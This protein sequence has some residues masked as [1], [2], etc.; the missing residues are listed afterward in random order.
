V[1]NRR[2]LWAL[3]WRD[4]KARY[5]GSV[6]GFVWTFLNPLLLM[7][8]YSLVFAVYMRVD[9]PHYPIFVF[10]GLLP[11]IWFSSAVVA[12]SNAI[13]EGASL[14]KRVAF[15]PQVLPAVTVTATLI[16][17]MLGLPL[18]L[19]FMVGFG[20]PIRV[21]VLTLPLTIAFQFVFTLGVVIAL[22]MLSV[23]YRD[24]HHLLASAMTLWFFLTPVLYPPSLVPASLQ[25]FLLLNPMTS[26][27]AAYQ[28]ALYHGQAPELAHLV[29]GGAFA[30]GALAAALALCGRWR[31]TLVEEV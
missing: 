14:I 4:L 2:V 22:S 1:A 24:L 25:P 8:I 7:A 5:R 30:F 23:R 17:F 27:I 29:V 31:W 13:V 6:L 9:I 19:A 15:P 12:G 28:A 11:W 10:A 3:V 18:L 26:I 20:V 21:A 16:N